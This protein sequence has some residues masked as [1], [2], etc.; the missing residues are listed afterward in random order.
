M[1]LTDKLTAIGDAIRSK[2]GKTA[3]IPLAQMPA[4]IINL[5]S[6][7]FEV[8][9]CK[10]VSEL[11][12]TAKQNTIAVF[13][14]NMTGYSFNPAE[15]A[16][17]KEGMVWFKT[18]KS[19]IVAFDA[20]E[21]NPIQICPVGAYQ[22]SNGAFKSI[23]AKTYL[24]GWIDWKFDLYLIQ[25]G[26][27]NEDAFGKPTLNYAQI[28]A[29]G[30]TIGQNQSITAGNFVDFSEY[31]SVEIDVS[32]R[33][34]S[35]DLLVQF[36]DS[37]NNKSAEVRMGVS[38]TGKFTANLPVLDGNFKVRLYGVTNNNYYSLTVSDVRFIPQ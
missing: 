30:A 18:G 37:S 8:I 34:E 25:N 2:S 24:N 13:T 17:P 3:K 33:D 31:D 11:P 32:R 26:V 23:E 4:E 14:E 6:L 10:S 5:Q 22:Y 35:C 19:S 21:E 29:D 12:E 20:V 28:T 36:L 7:N 15:P 16:S 1:A 38:G 27:Y 9:V